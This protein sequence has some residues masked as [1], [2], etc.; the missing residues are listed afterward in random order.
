MGRG[1]LEVILLLIL[2]IIFP[3]IVALIERGEARFCS[4]DLDSRDCSESNR[5][6]AS[7]F[8]TRIAPRAG[9]LQDA[10]GPCCSTFC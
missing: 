9:C 5:A 3:P 7:L 6:V 8:S 1:I 4:A 10:P 2:A